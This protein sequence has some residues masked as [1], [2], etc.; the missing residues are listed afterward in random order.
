MS[1]RRFVAS[2]PA[3]LTLAE[4]RALFEFSAFLAASPLLRAIGRGDRHPVLVLPGFTAGDG[5]TAPLR[6]TLRSQGYWVHGWSLGRNLGPTQ[7]VVDGLDARLGYVFARHRRPVSVVGWSLGGI[8]AR[9]LARRHPHMVRQVITLGS[10]FQLKVGD[11]SRAHLLWDR[12]AGGF[13]DDFVELA[14]VPED[15]R[16]ALEV[17]ATAIYSRGDGVVKWYTCLER[18]GELRE[19]IEV[20]GSHAGLGWNP[21][22]LYAISDR[23]AQ[24][25]GTWK[26]FRA[27]P[28]MGHHYP[29]PVAYRPPAPRRPV[30][31][32]RK[33]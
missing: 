22:V 9:E 6:W 16:P 1:E 15:A 17:P 32:S 18:P 13:S 8:Y 30:D 10:P 19:N 24:R 11:R 29:K 4:Q 26:P 28:L 2:P 21:A 12:L 27:P 23:L 25:E 31:L 14:M 33:R 3:W 5:S 7:H 20:R